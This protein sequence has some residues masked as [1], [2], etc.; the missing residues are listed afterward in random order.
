MTEAAASL[1]A[2]AA[3]LE[4]LGLVVEPFGTASVLVREVPSLLGTCDV[5]DM[6]ADLAAELAEAEDSERPSFWPRGSTTCCR[7]WPATAA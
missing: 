7:P 2:A 1:C 3:E 5:K 4:R 6:L